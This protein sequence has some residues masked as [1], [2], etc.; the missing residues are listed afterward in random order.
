M[1]RTAFTAGHERREAPV[2]KTQTTMT[3][4]TGALVVPACA[5]YAAAGHRERYEAAGL[6]AV[7]PEFKGITLSSWT[8]AD[9]PTPVLIRY[10]GANG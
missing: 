6:A 2:I 7:S 5:A 9:N 10:G 3:G 8:G 4:A 1:G